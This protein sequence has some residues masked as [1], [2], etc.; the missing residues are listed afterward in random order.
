MSNLVESLKLDVEP[1]GAVSSDLDY[2]AISFRASQK[3]STMME[4]M[5][6]VLKKPISTLFTKEISEKLAKF[7]L[8]DERYMAV[9]ED[10][11]PMFNKLSGS[12]LGILE[13]KG[14]LEVEFDEVEFDFEL[15]SI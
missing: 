12:C 11:L 2:I 5:S 4:I 6:V 15:D 8:E 9:L 13:K 3:T 1:S 10:S 14:V 7:L